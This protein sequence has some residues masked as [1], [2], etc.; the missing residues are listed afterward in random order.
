LFA[1]LLSI[2]SVAVTWNGRDTEGEVSTALGTF[3]IPPNREGFA[4]TLETPR[5]V[6]KGF[7]MI[8]GIKVEN[9]ASYP[10]GVSLFDLALGGGITNASL[11]FVGDDGDEYRLSRVVQVG[12][13]SGLGAY[14]RFKE[15]GIWI[16][17]GES[18]SM[19]FDVV[20]VM[21]TPPGTHSWSR[22]EEFNPRGVLLQGDWEFLLRE[23][24]LRVAYGPASVTVRLPD[25]QEAVVLNSIERE[26]KSACWF[27]NILTSRWAL[28]TYDHLPPTTRRI[29]RL[30]DVLRQAVVSP[31]VGLRAIRDSNAEDWDYLQDLVRQVEYEC[32]LQL[33]QPTAAEKVAA[34]LSSGNI[35]QIKEHH[36][37]I[38]NLRNVMSR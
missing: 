1:I 25:D 24:Y 31:E 9:A 20:H 16:D 4:G 10:M 6:V 8:L 32:L 18:I 23:E 29:M 17:S 28:P 27:P 14:E 19:W 15:P 3:T 36:G 30:V 11:W 34:S 21:S 35:R 26:L 38:A 37:L 33:D 12:P 22:Q 2:A 5:E 13:P 7:P